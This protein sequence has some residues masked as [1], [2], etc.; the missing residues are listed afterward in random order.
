MRLRQHLLEFLILLLCLSEKTHGFEKGDNVVASRGTTAYFRD[1][2][3]RQVKEGEAIVVF[4]HD[5][6]S[7]KVFFLDT[8]SDGRQIALSIADDALKAG[9]RS[10]IEGQWAPSVYE[11]RSPWPA[12]EGRIT[13]VYN[14][15]VFD[16]SEGK[17]EAFSNDKNVNRKIKDLIESGLKSRIRVYGDF[18]RDRWGRIDKRGGFIASSIE[19]AEAP[20]PSTL[21]DVIINPT[22]YLE[23]ATI[24]EGEFDCNNTERKSFD[25]MQND[26]RLEVFY[27]KHIPRDSW[28]PILSEKNFSKAKVSVTGILHKYSNQ[29]NSY[30]LEATSVTISEP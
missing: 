17:V 26:K 1:K 15:Y 29:D 27:G 8:D 14:I 13:T 12:D 30:Y 22:D 2:A 28:R 5:K 24:M 19:I 10:S 18:W 9:P 4:K 23:K 20:K 7:G 21:V 3:A 25:M 16:V 11:S 6:D